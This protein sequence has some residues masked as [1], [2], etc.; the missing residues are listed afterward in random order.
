M[1]TKNFDDKF[2]TVSLHLST[3][4]TCVR[5][6]KVEEIEFKYFMAVLKASTMYFYT[7]YESN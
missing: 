2:K 6:F 4:F 5:C 3:K 7:F 1:K